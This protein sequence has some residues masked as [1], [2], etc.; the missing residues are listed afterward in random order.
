MKDIIMFVAAA[1]AIAT[2]ASFALAGCG[3]SESN[4]PEKAAEKDAAPLPEDVTPASAPDASTPVDAS[5]D[6]SAAAD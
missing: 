5:G 2:G 1:C 3:C 4:E 6:A